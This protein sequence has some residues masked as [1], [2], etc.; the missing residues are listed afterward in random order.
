MGALRSS[1]VR[2]LC[3]TAMVCSMAAAIPPAYHFT[4]KIWS[5][6][7]LAA[8]HS[9]PGHP[10]VPARTTPLRLKEPGVAAVPFRPKPVTWP[11]AGSGVARPA[12]AALLPAA[13]GS[14]PMAQ[15][16]NLPL[17]IGAV[18]SPLTRSAGT[19]A[20]LPVPAAVR[21]QLAGHAQ[22]AAAGIDG[23]IVT[24]SRAD[25]GSGADTVL[26]RL[27]YAGFAADYGGAW[28]S[29]LRLAEIPACMLTTPARAGCHTVRPLASTDDA[30]TQTLSAAVP[31]SSAVDL[32]ATPGPSGP[33]GNYS[34]TSLNSAGTWAV[35]DGDFSYSYPISVP[36]SLGESAPDVTLHYDS[37]SIDGETSGRNTQASWIG[38]GWDYSP[39]FIERSYK[40]CSKD[41][42]ANS[43]D[44]CWGG[45]NATLSLGGHSG[46]LVRDDTTGDWHLQNDDGSKVQ[47]LT[48]AGNGLWSGEYWLVTTSDGTKYYFGLNHLP[49]GSGTDAATNSAWGVPVYSPNSGD[50]CNSLTWCQM[51]WR[52]NLDY[53]VD[54][55]GDL[56][57]YNYT[58]ETNDYD[59]GAGQNSGNGTLTQYVRGGYLDSIGYGYRLSDAIGGASPAAQVDFGTAQRC[60]SSSTYTCGTAGPTSS[61]AS[62]WPDVPYD[63]NCA[64]TG[65][66]TNY[67]PTF[68]S[69]MR[70]DT[71]TTK[72]GSST[73]DTYQ[74]AQ[75][76]PDASGASQP[77]MFLNS[78]TRTGKDGGSIA[79]PPVTFT[80]TEVDNRV[81]GLVPAAP[82]LYRPRI[83]DIATETGGSIAIQYEPPSCSRV[84]NT[85]PAS[86]D[87]N[88]MP[89]FPVYWTPPG[90]ASP[91]QDWFK[92][93]LVEQ[94]DTADNTGI[95]SPAQVT[96]YQYED[97]AAWHQD[98][99]P[100]TDNT[101]RTWDQF[102]GYA[103]VITESGASPD[104]VTET[105]TTYMRGMNGDATS[106]GGTKSVTVTDSLG[107]SITDD[108]WLAGQALETDTYKQ[109]DGT[110]D[111]KTISG[112]WTFRSTASQAMPSGLPALV[113]RMPVNEESRQLSLLASGSWRDE[114][115]DTGYNTADQV[116][117]SDHKGDGSVSDPQICTTTSYA[118]SS[119]NPMI[120]SYPD[121]IKAVTGACGSAANATNT[122]ADTRTFYDGSGTLSNMGTF[123]TISGAGDATGI[124]VISGYDSSGN[125]VFEP[126]SATSYDVYGRTL[127]STD[128]NGNV[129]KTAYTPATGALPT[130]TV[131]TNP[132]G[133]TTTTLLDQARQLP[134][135]VTDPNGRLTSESYDALGRLTA[136]WV[137][138]RS[139]SGGQ[140][141]NKT[142]SYSIPGT[143][144]VAVTTQT[145]REDGSYSSDIKIYDGLMQIRQEQTSTADGSAGRLITDTFHDSHGWVVKTSA[146]YY[147]STTSPDSTVDSVADD[148]VPSQT[149]TK[150]DGQGRVTAT[151]FY[152]LAVLQW[153]TT[154]AYPG[155]DETDVTPPAGGTATSTFTNGRGQTTA[156]WSYLTTAPD[157]KA[158][159]ADVTSYTYTP[160]G[161]TATIADNSGNKSTYT[162]NLLGQKIS[163][164][165]PDAGASTYTYDANGNLQSSTDARSQTLTYT[166]DALNRKTAEHNGSAELASWTY[167]TLA[168]GQLTSSTAYYNGNAYTETVAGYTTSYEPTGTSV[169]I[170]SAEGALYGTY[171]TTNTYTPNI[172]LLNSTEYSADGGLPDETVSYSYDLQG[173]LNAF[174]GSTAY[175]DKTSYTPFGQVQRTTTGLY[176]DQLVLTSSYDQ[177]T[178][179]LLQT[180]T[181]LQTLSAA[182]D[183]V[184]YT[185]ND[186]GSLTSVSDAQYGGQTDLQC[187]Q[188]DNLQRLT[189]AWT[190]T[191]GTSTAGGTSVPGVGGCTNTTPA[192]STV[193]G[194]APYWESFGYDLLGDRTSETIHASAG[195]T[196][197]TLSYSGAKPNEVSSVSTASPTGTTTQSY[198]YNAA[199]DT[200]SR[201]GQTFTYDPQGRTS[202]V[203]TAAGTSG[204]LYDADGNLLIQRDP[205]STTLYL[206]S[207]AEQL[208]LAG[209]KVTGL[210]LYSQPGGTTIV[211]SSAGTISYTVANQQ[212]TSSE[213]IDAATLAVTRRYYDPYG[214]PRGTTATSWPD[215]LG[216]VGKPADAATSLDLLGARQYDPVTGRFLEV[217]PVLEAG[218]SRQMGGYA[219]A[220]DNPVNS[221]DPSG[222]MIEMPGDGGGGGWNGPTDN[223]DNAGQCWGP[224]GEWLCGSSQPP[225][226]SV[227]SLT[228]SGSSDSGSS[229]PDPGCIGVHEECG[230]GTRAMGGGGTGGGINWGHI[231][232]KAVVFVGN[233]TGVTD[234]ITCIKSHTLKSCAAAG[235]KL[236]GVAL[237]VATGGLGSGADEGISAAADTLDASAGSTDAAATSTDVAS[238]STD[239]SVTSGDASTSGASAATKDSGAV[240]PTNAAAETARMRIP[241]SI[242]KTACAVGGA[243]A[244]CLGGGQASEV[245]PGT[246][247]QVV[248]HQNVEFDLE[249]MELSEWE[250]DVLYGY[251]ARDI[252]P[253]LVG[254]G[255]SIALNFLAVP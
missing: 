32:A 197:Q 168:K 118:T 30:A 172:G 204:Y 96:T 70:L 185:Y 99:S 58:A 173:L 60:V 105:E 73:V 134:T 144:P 95:D 37:Q 251:G 212:G 196:S 49:G 40:S 52:W 151:Q 78:I 71:I 27:G 90:E 189:Q 108:N 211:R 42:I 178:Q 158:A 116:T 208:V 100:V 64:S 7:A 102:R 216:F 106:S 114:Q 159:D 20:T 91:I 23:P 238:A 177:G 65:T 148:N 229:Q 202:S 255:T 56:Q 201:S 38:D 113:A 88:T 112:P 161:Q 140:S 72:V 205:G 46:V 182:E 228:S 215:N 154:K 75:T 192:Q 176:G 213:S 6:S 69:T 253:S 248:V 93:S 137:P 127:T 67:G 59:R 142:F 244:I 77:V 121:E 61:T 166:Y 217:D 224:G 119:A 83:S 28:A 220:A 194:P 143:K 80:P 68:W 33:E 66:C 126:K 18:D 164:T 223:G 156:T 94:V 9:V 124:E 92:K 139:K 254:G 129:T 171:T 39:G 226:S 117:T 41:G 249:R 89:C 232:K 214:D 135:Q 247:T 165:D 101:Y 79:V 10:L 219:Y 1:L 167:D 195:N 163:Q 115:T 145:L 174:G 12:A 29:R 3:A 22:S 193:G 180:T 57:V 184:N 198:A 122:V 239:A 181:N 183:T 175:L 82:P 50:P 11:A 190:D 107:D 218:D 146:P 222:L 227:P 103:K 132:M 74:L 128:A 125:P 237:A 14:R 157:Q 53:V 136:V 120:E 62:N 150:Y 234:A 44:E 160:S 81:D 43:D 54:P 221:S 84:N 130:Q 203:T 240:G 231:F 76:Y 162:Y 252:P 34:A 152:S 149:V 97:G 133:W 17:W 169:T 225:A 236:S 25:G 109:A 187:F 209:G 21:V 179:R 16:G 246:I 147:D 141:A 35:Q 19:G 86:A 131:V 85:M 31:L 51:G 235:I 188:Y 13:G 15:A 110:V 4:G 200:T 98:V 245:M 243:V 207:G 24:L 155:M 186:A 230:T 26:V 111:S 45:N 104:P 210:R 206:D 170:P 2:V 55:H 191:G 153:Q 36:P 199:G 138:G 233:A 47:L 87:T 250:P 63:Q 241:M 242:R 8:A 5:P 123:G 48:G